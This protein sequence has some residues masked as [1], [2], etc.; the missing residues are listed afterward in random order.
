MKAFW[1][2]SFIA[3]VA[4]LP[5][6]LAQLPAVANP[7]QKEAVMSSH[8]SGAFDVKMSAQDDRLNDGISRYL[9]DKQYHGDLEGTSKGQM[10]STGNPNSSA[11]YV[12]IETFSGTLRSSSGKSKSGSFALHHTG[13]MSKGTPSLSINVVPDSGTGQ[14]AGISGT[15]KINIAADGKHSYDFEYTLP[16]Q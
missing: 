4:S 12:A 1:I 5:V 6:P 13:I 9:S 10:L 3:I 14:L 2:G 8:A 11:V 15:M 7:A 16:N